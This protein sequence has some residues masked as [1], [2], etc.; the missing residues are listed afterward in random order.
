MTGHV[1]ALYACM[2]I[3]HATHSAK[4]TAVYA[5]WNLCGFISLYIYICFTVACGVLLVSIILISMLSR[6][7]IH[8][9]WQ[10]NGTLHYHVYSYFNFLDI[11]CDV[12][13]NVLIPIFRIPSN[14]W[15]CYLRTGIYSNPCKVQ[16]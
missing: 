2:Y 3:F 13:C 9:H 15:T 10:F 11:A 4:Y 14:H 12:Q 16:M 5:A 6:A 1:A 8:L 7:F